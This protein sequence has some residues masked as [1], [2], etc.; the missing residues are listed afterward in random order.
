MTAAA[1]VCGSCGTELPPDS[2]FCN[3]CGAPITPAATS[4]E[5]KQVTVLFADVVRSMDIAAALDME[6]LREIMTELVERSAAVV[7]R[8]GGG[9]V[10]YTG[11]GVMA[12]FGAPVALEDHAFRACL[13]ALAIQEEANRLAVEVQRRDGVVLRL[14]VGLNSG[15]VIAGE[16]GSGSLGYAAIGEHVGF[17]QRM[18]SVAPPGGVMLSESTARLV[19][20]VVMLAEPEWVRIKGRDEPVR[21]RQ[22]VAISARAGL[23]GR[24]EASLVGRRW[25][26]AALDA[27]VDRTVGGRGGAVNVVGAPGI[28][29]SRTARETAALAGGRGVEVFWAFCESHA[30]DISFG[31]VARLLRA[32]TGVA[33]LD[34]DAAR[35]RVR[36]Q[37]PDADPQDLL[38]LD[39]LL[40]IADPDVP[41]PKIDPDARRRRL[42]ALVNAAALARSEPALF[43]IE[44]AQWIDAV[45]ESMLADFLSVI[46]QT[47]SMVL[48]TARPE[49]QGALTRVPGAQ[50]IA[51]APLG[52]A[53]TAALIGELLGS[54]P[55]V[56]ELAATLAD[57]AAGNP[58]FAEEMVRELVQRGVLQGVRGGYT[59]E[60]DVA[61]VSV[62]ATVQ[63]AIEARIDRLTTPAK[64]TLHAASVI[65]AR[66]DAE[67]LAALG[68][69]AVVDEPLGAELIDQVRFTPAAEYAFRHPLIRAVAYESQLK[70]DRA[71]SHRRLAAAIQ[72]RDPASVEDNA[73][74]IAEHLEAAGD[75]HAAYGWH[76]RAATWATNRDINAAVLSWE[77]ARRIAD[78][79]P[80]DDP[81]RAAMRI[82]AR[83]MLC[84][85]AFRVH[86]HVAGARFEELRELCA[87]AGD[88]PSLAIGMAGL[89]ADHA[90]QDRVREASQLASETWALIESVG[91]ATL[92]VGLSFP[93]VYAK[94]EAAECRDLL[95][96]SQRVID[97]ADG[98]PSK[99][100]FIVGSPLAFAFALRAMGRYCLGR[101]GWRDDMRHGLVMARSADP[102][103]Y[104][105]A[106][107]L[108]YVGGIPFGV[109]TADDRAVREIEDALQLAERSGDDFQLA[110]GRG[111]LGIALVHRHTAAER[112]RGQQLLAEVGEMLLRRGFF[113][114][115]LPIVNVY[116]ARERARRGDRDEAIAL[117]RAAVDHL[118]R[119]GQLLLWGT[120]ATGVLV[121]TLLDRGT[122]GDVAEA[123]AA[124]DRLAA[125]PADDGLVIREIWLLRLRALLARS[126]GDAVAYTDFRDRYREMAKSLGFEGHIAWA[127][128]M[129]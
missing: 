76:M 51:L 30:R 7:Q 64:R 23:V 74:L 44:D 13:A 99:G 83:T 121:E 63:A 47:P 49:Y 129:T 108:V 1:L 55:S 77:R 62:P 28:G 24:A 119:E 53:D 123:E 54:D 125:A 60:A 109:L 38:L 124:I 35:A 85:I 111:T 112:G 58:F 36:E 105:T 122:D 107:A 34:G 15:R 6:R 10:E 26:M 48:I 12:I 11:D 79:L 116:A 82:A 66:F 128:A 114:A 94:L 59:C 41:P 113:L 104:A 57:R 73:A 78:A 27:M 118:F 65:G 100:N 110:Q 14:R 84:G 8:Y 106:V 93:L 39:D 61:E 127:E 19:E 22:L 71:Q 18:E 70:S 50:T 43:I 20:H 115:E 52:N 46:P 102:A 31:V 67:L 81:N 75:L 5:Y 97:L 120:A 88:K 87:A 40:G 98:D 126:H 25:E 68:I 72:E 90:W 37:V 89:V 69:D 92:T 32:G 101:P 95:R 3:K 91:D 29:K 42:T 45:S 33:D 16:I 80:V 117:M 21:A 96:W 2:R 56:G 103:S 17:A 9:G 86:E 4:A